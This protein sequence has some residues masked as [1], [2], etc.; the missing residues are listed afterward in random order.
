MS[1]IT[2]YYIASSVH[3]DEPNPVRWLPARRNKIALPCPLGNTRRVPQENIPPKLVPPKLAWKFYPSGQDGWILALKRNTQKRTWP[4][5][6]H[7]DLP[8]NH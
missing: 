3:E 2:A 5:P 6:N 4:I 8:L 1:C 7:L